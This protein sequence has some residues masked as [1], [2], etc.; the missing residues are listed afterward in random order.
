[1][2]ERLLTIWLKPQDTKSPNCSSTTGR[3]PSSAK[4]SAAPTAPDSMIGVL[5]TRSSP[6]RSRS[7]SVALKTPP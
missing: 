6:N 2:V 1:V 4:P 5:R 3:K 7:P